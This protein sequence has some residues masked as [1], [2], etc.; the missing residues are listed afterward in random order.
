MIRR[1]PRSTRTDTLFP[2]TTLFRSLLIVAG[3]IADAHGIA[4]ALALGGDIACMGTRF[5]AT[6]ESGVVEG[7]RAMIPTVS[8]DDIVA[9]A[10]MNG[11]PAHWMR[12][13]IEAVGLDPRT[14]PNIRSDMPEGVMPWRDIWSAGAR[15]GLIDAVEPVAGPG[16]RLA[17]APQALQIGRAAGWGA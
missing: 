2:Y 14:L 5:I 15:A 12:Q 6:P 10:A 3:G 13:S 17:P 1:P 11:V 8:A 4:A 9:S 16:A 7:H